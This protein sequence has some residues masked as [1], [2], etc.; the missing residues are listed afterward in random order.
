MIST[1]TVAKNAA[2]HSVHQLGG[3][4]EKHGEVTL[5]GESLSQIKKELGKYFSIVGFSRIDN[6]E[7]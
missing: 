5:T 2:R 6:R 7:R 1:R 3:F 4:Q